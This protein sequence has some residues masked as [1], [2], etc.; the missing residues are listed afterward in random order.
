VIISFF[1]NLHGFLTDVHSNCR[2]YAPRHL[3]SAI[4]LA[5]QDSVRVFK[6]VK[7][8]RAI[9]MHWGFAFFSNLFVFTT[10]TAS[11]LYSTWVLTTEPVMEPPFRLRE[12]CEKANIGD[13][14][15]TVC[16]IGETVAV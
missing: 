2:A 15:F 3:M 4:H 11:H 7:A 13:K 16:D 14:E 6:D 8:K 9:G 10:L 12:E 1:A 5:P